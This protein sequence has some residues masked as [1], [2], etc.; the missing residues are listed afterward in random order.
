MRARAR[1]ARRASGRTL[2]EPRRR[3]GGV[4]RR[5]RARRGRDAAARRA[6]T[7]KS[8]RIRQAV[9]RHGARALRGATLAVTLEPC[10]HHGRT[11]PCTDAIRAAGIARVLVGPRDPHPHVVGTRHSRA[12]PRRHRGSL[13]VLEAECRVQHRGFLSRPASAAAP[14]SRSSSRRPSTAASRRRAASRAGSRAKRRAR[15]CTA[16]ATPRMP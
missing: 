6:A 11:P 16:C 10:G 13:G 8:S 4:P 3:R 7:P 15:S 9:R 5:T 2:P 1:A 12:A 14:S